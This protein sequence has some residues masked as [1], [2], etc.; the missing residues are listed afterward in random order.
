MVCGACLIQCTGVFFGNVWR[1]ARCLRFPSARSLCWIYDR[2]Y[3]L[4]IYDGEFVIAD[5]ILCSSYQTQHFPCVKSVIATKLG[6]NGF[7][8]VIVDRE[9]ERATHYL[10]RYRFHSAIG[11]KHLML[12]SPY[13]SAKSERAQAQ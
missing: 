12:K 7:S 5:R 11:I 10:A 4:E 8:F 2:E 9:S 6:G 13:D 3:V 1:D